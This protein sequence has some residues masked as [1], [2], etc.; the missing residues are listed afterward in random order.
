MKI[1]PNVKTSSCLGVS[2]SYMVRS[3]VLSDR[4]C[5]F[6]FFFLTVERYGLEVLL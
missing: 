4:G 3:F 1:V 6:V 5:C 2:Y